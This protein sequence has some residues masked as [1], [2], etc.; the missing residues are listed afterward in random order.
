MNSAHPLTDDAVKF[1]ELLLSE[2]GEGT[3]DHSWRKCRRCQ[4]FNLLQGYDPLSR[5]LVQHVIE[6]LQFKPAAGPP[7]SVE[8]ERDAAL[9]ELQIAFDQISRINDQAQRAFNITLTRA[10]T[11]EAALIAERS[12]LREQIERLRDEANRDM[13]HISTLPG[14]YMDAVRYN[15]VWAE[16]RA[17]NRVLALWADPATESETK[18]PQ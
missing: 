4:A 7:P 9:F 15:Q 5:R 16:C 13:Q 10:E 11:A 1:L 3:G 8:K 2:C 12:R 18:P 17:Y 14:F 6:R